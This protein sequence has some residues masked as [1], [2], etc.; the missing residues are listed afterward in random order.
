MVKSTAETFH[1]DLMKILDDYVDDIER[2][3]AECVKKVA[4]KGAKALRNSSP[5]QTGRYAS[6]WTVK[7]EDKRTGAVATI[8]NGKSPGLPHLLE[9]GHVIRNGTGRTYGSTKA[10]EHIK[11]IEEQIIEEFGNDLKKV[12]QQ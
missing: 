9:H 11:P 4:Q 8:Y 5:K 6:G 2:G 7:T 12:I 1:N 3:S 10:I